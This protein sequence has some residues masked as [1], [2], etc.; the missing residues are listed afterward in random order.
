VSD[1]RTPG[2]A[3]A[4]R[5][6]RAATFAYPIAFRRRFASEMQWAFEERCSDSWKDRGHRGLA[7]AVS[8]TLLDVVRAG[9]GERFEGRRPASAPGPHLRPDPPDHVPMFSSTLQD[10]RFA[11]RLLRKNPGFTLVAVLTLALGIGANTAIFTLV[12]SLLGR[13]LPGIEDPDSLFALYTDEGGSPG[14]SS[15]VDYRDFAEQ[16]NTVSGIAAYKPRQAAVGN[17]GVIERLSS[18]MVTGSYFDVV[19]VNAALGRTIGPD[20]DIEPDGHPIAVISYG[21]WQRRFA[22]DPGVLGGELQVNGRAFTIIGVTPRGFRGTWLESG[23]DLFVPMAMQPHMMPGNGNLL[24][25]RGWGGVL[26]LGRVAEGESIETVRAEI[27][28]VGEWLRATFVEAQGRDY[29]VV[30]FAEGTLAP[31]ARAM[32]VQL[33][34]LETLMSNALA[35]ERLTATAVGAAA[36]L[37]LALALVGLYGIL[38]Y[39]V[40]RRSAELGV[41][42]A[43]GADASHLVRMVLRQA[44][45]LVALGLV[46]GLAGAAALAGLV[47]GFLFDV[48]ALDLVT[49]VGVLALMLAVSL[50][51]AWLPARRATRLDPVRAL[52]AE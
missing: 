1:V 42:M 50:A 33:G 14:V 16:L 15:I 21:L 39:N 20:D 48:A 47:E 18:M 31:Q 37:A 25:R 49:Y 12:D 11:A 51:A 34:T 35:Q 3:L 4:A 38:T 29:Q 24:E 22:G 32:V 6:L 2:L 26:I 7:A 27:G 41:R 10:V 45:A 23:P 40:S 36:L 30:S 44:S 28:S 52:R 43:L 8:R 9:L 46:F 19:G 17:D 5:L 13:P